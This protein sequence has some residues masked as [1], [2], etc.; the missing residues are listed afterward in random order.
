MLAL[1]ELA[2]GKHSQNLISPSRFVDI[3]LTNND[4]LGCFCVVHPSLKIVAHMA[5]T[6]HGKP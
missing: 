4:K 1:S 3:L 2:D 6:R 5:N